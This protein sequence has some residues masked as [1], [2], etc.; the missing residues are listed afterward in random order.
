MPQHLL[1]GNAKDLKRLSSRRIQIKIEGHKP[2]RW[3]LK[4]LEKLDAGLPYAS[5]DER[6]S[7]REARAERGLIH[8]KI[9]RLP[10]IRMISVIPDEG[11]KSL[12]PCIK[13]VDLDSDAS[14]TFDC[15]GFSLECD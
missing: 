10:C 8:W 12:S 5:E 13:T 6:G 14:F 4:V 3:G 9:A 11:W 2:D 7:T 1:V 15:L